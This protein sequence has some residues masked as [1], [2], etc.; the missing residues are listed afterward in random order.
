MQL[1]K[2]SVNQNIK[3]IKNV[4]KNKMYKD[5][6]YINIFTANYTNG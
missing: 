4:F 5:Y 1:K 2:N 6:N 3:C